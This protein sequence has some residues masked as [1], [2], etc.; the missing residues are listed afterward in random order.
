VNSCSDCPWLRSPLIVSA[1]VLCVIACAQKLTVAE[2][3]LVDDRD[4]V[5]ERARAS[6]PAAAST[7]L[8][9]AIKGPAESKPE[10]NDTLNKPTAAPVPETAAQALSKA[11]WTVV[12]GDWK[13]KSAGVYEVINGK[14][15]AKKINGGI[16][17]ALIKGG[18]G[19]VSA[20][21]RNGYPAKNTADKPDEFATGYGICASEKTYKL[22]TPRMASG[23]KKLQPQ[24]ERE[25]KLPLGSTRNEYSIMIQ[26]KQ[27]EMY[28]NSK[29]EKLTMYEL[30]ETG[31]F[32]LEVKGTATVESPQAA[33]N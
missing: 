28:V 20:Y 8:A 12:S 19:I 18:D 33:G 22:Y 31:S 15:E 13:Q 27:F 23:S 10:R 2:E 29:R 14:L 30:P 24:L 16:R 5:A 6:Q 7:A 25:S 3:G 1:V 4:P 21:V 17:F 11:G 9:N 26:G 32:V